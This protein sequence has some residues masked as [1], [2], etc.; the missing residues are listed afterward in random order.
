MNPPNNSTAAKPAMT[1]GCQKLGKRVRPER[2][3]SLVHQASSREQANV[4][5]YSSAHH[6]QSARRESDSGAV[7]RSA[8]LDSVMDLTTAFRRAVNT[9][10]MEMG[11]PSLGHGFPFMRTKNWEQRE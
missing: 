8:W 3:A 6:L 2:A 9:L 5:G 10:V 11:L 7:Q 1:L 4:Q